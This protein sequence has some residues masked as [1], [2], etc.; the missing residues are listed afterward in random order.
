MDNIGILKT[1]YYM[2]DSIHFT[3]VCKKLVSKTL[4]LA[5]SLYKSCNIHKFD[6]SRCYLLGMIKFTEFYDSL[7]RYRNDSDVRIDRCEW[8]ICG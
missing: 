2:Y 4:A 6:G 3:N 7:I 8:I 1:T 5:G